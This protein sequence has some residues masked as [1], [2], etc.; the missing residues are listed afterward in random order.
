MRLSS[1]IVIDDKLCHDIV[2]VAQVES[3]A[4]GECFQS[5]VW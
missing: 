5:E 4:G 1:Y 3:L 2:Q